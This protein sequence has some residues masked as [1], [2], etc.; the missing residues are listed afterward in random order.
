MRSPHVA[1]RGIAQEKWVSE[2][3][4]EQRNWEVLGAGEG[5]SLL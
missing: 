5:A 1:G 3:L 2:K 4:R